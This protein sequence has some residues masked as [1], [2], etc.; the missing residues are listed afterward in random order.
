MQ[1]W[2]VT[3]QCCIH[4]SYQPDGV[5]TLPKGQHD[6][7]LQ[8][9]R[10][11]AWHWCIITA[12]VV[13]RQHAVPNGFKGLSPALRL[14]KA[15]RF[16]TPPHLHLCFKALLD[17]LSVLSWNCRLAFS[18]MNMFLN[19]ATGFSQAKQRNICVES[20]C[21]FELAHWSY[22]RRCLLKGVD[23]GEAYM[24]MRIIWQR[25]HLNSEQYRCVF[26]V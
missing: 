21:D 5:E 12:K 14:I 19:I 24:C 8:C 7:E 17:L 23:K 3:R 18:Y 4:A 1:P 25:I 16:A 20:T 26:T 10:V 11:N 22:T 6:T 13:L 2:L 9:N 15:D